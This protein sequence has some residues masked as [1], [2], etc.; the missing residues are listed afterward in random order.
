MPRIPDFLVS[1]AG[2]LLVLGGIRLFQF[3]W[4]T[5]PRVVNRETVS[6]VVFGVLTTIINI[7]TYLLCSTAFTAARAMNEVVINLVSNVIAWVV[8]VIFAYVVNKLFVFQSRVDT[9]RAAVKEC[10]LFIGARLLS[11]GVDAVGMVLM[12]NVARLN[13]AFSK[14]AMNVVVMVMN[15]FFSKWIIFTGKKGKELSPPERE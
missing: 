8:A 11:L 2:A 12:V 15:Y 5:Y 9:L 13:K 4:K 3:A 6:Y 7:V 1:F 10:G 14:I